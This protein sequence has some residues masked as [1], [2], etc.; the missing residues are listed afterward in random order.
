ML[1]V[2]G[3]TLDPN[4]SSEIEIL[5]IASGISSRPHEQAVINTYKSEDVN[6]LDDDLAFVESVHIENTEHDYTDIPAIT[7]KLMANKVTEPNN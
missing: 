6:Y 1:I 5:I 7:R 4:L 2:P 3:V